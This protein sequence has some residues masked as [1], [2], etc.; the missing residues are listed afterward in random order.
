LPTQAS[1]G[2]R[3]MWRS[4]TLNHFDGGNSAEVRQFWVDG[5]D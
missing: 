4:V 3:G 1:W 2:C 5:G